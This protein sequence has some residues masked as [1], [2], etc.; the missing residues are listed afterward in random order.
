MLRVHVKSMK[1]KEG[2]SVDEDLAARRNPGTTR[3]VTLGG[4]VTIFTVKIY[5]IIVEKS[6]LTLADCSE[7]Y[8][9]ITPPLWKEGTIVRHALLPKIYPHCLSIMNFLFGLER[10]SIPSERPEGLTALR[11]LIACSLRTLKDAIETE[12]MQAPIELG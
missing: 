7:T 9:I 11:A 3:H 2:I 6:S 8:F 10:M 1:V 5:R 12:S 4:V